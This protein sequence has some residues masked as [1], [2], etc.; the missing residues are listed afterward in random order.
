MISMSQRELITLEMD[1]RGYLQPILAKNV[2]LY[3]ILN[4]FSS[5]FLKDIGCI[6]TWKLRKTSIL[7][8]KG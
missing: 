1:W 4:G 8:E 3:S 5:R 2:Y 7:I 6:S